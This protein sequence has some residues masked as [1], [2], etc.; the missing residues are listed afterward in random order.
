MQGMY[1]SVCELLML[2][3]A[4]AQGHMEHGQPDAEAVRRAVFGPPLADFDALLLL[5]RDALSAADLALQGPK[6][7]RAAAAKVGFVPLPGAQPGQEDRAARALLRAVP[8][9]EASSLCGSRLNVI[10]L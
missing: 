6:L 7:W 1:V 10:L 9:G 2:L 4:P 3:P 5:R 8:Q